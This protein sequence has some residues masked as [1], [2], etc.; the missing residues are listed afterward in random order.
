MRWLVVA[1]LLA[2]AGLAAASTLDRVDVRRSPVVAVR[3]EVTEP[4][5]PD[6]HTIP[7]A[8]DL[9]PRIYLD[10]PD[11]VLGDVAAS[12]VA[13]SGGLVRVRTGQFTA[14]TARVVLDLDRPTDYVIRRTG[15]TITIELT[16][17]D[18]PARPTPPPA[19]VVSAAPPPRTDVPPPTES[20]SAATTAA[21]SPISTPR[22]TPPAPAASWSTVAPPSVAAPPVITA[23]AAIAPPS[24]VGRRPLVVIDAG[25]GGRDPG[26][27]GL[28]G[29]LEKAL[30]LELA[31]RVALRL[32]AR[33]PVAVE[34]TRHDDAFLPIDTRIALASDAALFIS[35]HA[36]ASLDPHM[37]GIEVF[38]GGGGPMAA[39]SGAESPVRLGL[40]VV[41]ALEQR[42]GDVHT[43][44]RPGEYGVLARNAVPSVLI[45]V[46]YLTNANDAAHLRDT[47]YRDRLADAVVDAVD[48]FLHDRIAS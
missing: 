23:P 19:P 25:H 24:D 7:A 26:A 16:G 9:P 45:E 2:T 32:P 33:L 12:S 18:A 22:A 48:A 4:V 11:T 6:V 46:G 28:D 37:H 17:L 13:A 44:V 8:G 39:A 36:N 21:A 29:V 43:L 15:T 1:P 3:L 20:R 34:L 5:E 10:L 35:L 38:F 30:T 40:A 14:T 47:T 27:T 31:R 42:L 41:D